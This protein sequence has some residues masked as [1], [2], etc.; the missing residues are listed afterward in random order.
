MNRFRLLI[1]AMVIWLVLILNIERPDN[2]FGLG[3]VDL[4]PTFYGV[5]L[6]ITVSV[7]T[8]PEVAQVPL[9][10]S[11]IVVAAFHA[12]LTVIAEALGSSHALWS[13]GTALEIGMVLVTLGLARGFSC[14]ILWYETTV[15]SAVVGDANPM[16]HNLQMDETTIADELLRARRYSY[17]ITLLYIRL[18]MV[19]ALQNG[20]KTRWNRRRALKKRYLQAHITELV[21]SLLLDTVDIITW[22][23]NNLMIFLPQ[24]PKSAVSVQIRQLEEVFQNVLNLSF[25]IGVASFPENALVLPDL[26]N[27]AR[28]DSLSPK[29]RK[30]PAVTAGSSTVE[31]KAEAKT[32]SFPSEIS[33]LAKKKDRIDLSA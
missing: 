10:I 23:K 8:I 2:I 1:L 26:I 19:D 5:A 29:P 9:L 13:Y 32:I 11:S 7:L 14:S 20:Y 22:H 24:K 17:P 12:A 16:R 4:S 21:R 6:L 18:D 28:S 25:T 15:D 3:H 31:T 30:Q 27:A 33:E